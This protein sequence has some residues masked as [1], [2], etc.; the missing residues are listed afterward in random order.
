M[1]IK[2][3]FA[4][5]ISLVGLLQVNAEST[6]S[7]LTL[8][9]CVSMA[10][11]NNKK[12]LTAKNNIDAAVYMK[13]EAFTKYFPEIAAT[14]M[15]FWAN[16]DVIQYNL[17][18]IVELGLIKHGKVAGIQAL[19][20]IFMGGQIVN[21]NKLADVAE[22][23]AKLRKEQTN[24]E[25]RLTVET[26]YWK[27]VTLKSTKMT[28]NDAIV[29][30]DSLTAEVNAAV[31]A[32][33]A[34]NNDL[35]K[36]E[37]K[38][39]SYKS[40]MVDLDNG[41]QLMKMLLGQYVGLGT[42]GKIDIDTAVPSCSP[43]MP[44]NLY[45]QSQDALLNLNDYKLLQ[46]NVEAKKIEK[47]MTIGSN[48]PSLAFGAGWYYHD[49]LEQNHNF[50]ALELDVT[51]PLSG[52]WGGTYAIKQKNVAIENARL[53]ME[54]LSEELQINMQ[55]KW[56]DLTAFH[57]KMQI[58]EEGIKQS[59]EN[60]RINRMYY[61]AGMSTVSDLLEAETELKQAKDRFIA[62]YGNF[63][64]AKAAYLIATGR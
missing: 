59:E 63:C 12:A 8:D 11:E 34:L 31:E 64:T 32:G 14:G 29:T 27:L 56:N 46:K 49:L 51:I 35:L 33:I 20:P 57:R 48:L 13:R 2:I 53:E 17:L 15:A 47:R 21:G 4:F 62:A 28:L 25:L 39:N 54:N 24:D 55:N 43:D 58:E 36:V 41:I 9:R 7:L 44:E 50:G 16:H 6:D 19:Q 1:K 60:L 38:R 5:V 30:L 42:S 61:E 10:L 37:L 22:E 26:M 40:E 45:V 23:V 3:F 18:D 52:W